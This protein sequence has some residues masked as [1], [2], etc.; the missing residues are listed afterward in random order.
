[1]EIGDTLIFYTDGLTEIRDL[2]GESFGEERLIQEIERHAREH[3]ARRLRDSILNSV[4]SF[5]ADVAQEDDLTLL[6][7]KIR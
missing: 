2:R 5:K 3:S 6:I 4:S 1:M 7:L